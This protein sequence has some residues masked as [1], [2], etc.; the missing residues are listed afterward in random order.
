MSATGV[1]W[2]TMA[3]ILSSGGCNAAWDG[4]RPLTGGAD[5]RRSP[6][7]R[8]GRRRAVPRSAAGAAT[9][10]ARTARRRRRSPAPCR[11][12]STPRPRGDR[13]R[14]REHRRVRER[15]RPGPH[16]RTRLKIVKQNNPGVKTSSPSAPRPPARPTDGTRLINR[17]R[18]SRANIDIFTIMPFDFGGGSNMYQS[19]VNAS[20]GLK[21][22]LK[23][24]FGWSDAQAYAH[25]GISGMNGLSDQQELTTTATW[26]Q[27]RDYAKS[28]GLTRLAYW[29][30]N[31]DRP[32]RA[33]ES[34]PTAAGSPSPTGTS[35]GSRGLLTGPVSPPSPAP[36]R[37]RSPPV[38]ARRLEGTKRLQP[39]TVA[40]DSRR[41]AAIALGLIAL[42]ATPAA[43]ANILTNPGFES[44][45]V[46]LD[47]LSHGRGPG[48]D[49][50]RSRRYARPCRPPR[51]ARTTPD[52]SRP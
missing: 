24:A 12:S 13:H 5:A 8:G 27:I 23:T 22:T 31:R 26:T 10:S 19:T 52:A 32:C 37:A 20:E 17:A 38:R 43:A 14:H 21:N 11:R 34:S 29:A 28:K 51:R 16:P 1:K 4:S 15:G 2:F 49:A 45:P 48:G 33:A 9:S 18:S 44:R 42:H 46:R 30:V 35:P 47:L 6:R 40:R 25:M 36:H 41:A 50:A 7:S 3:F 39:G